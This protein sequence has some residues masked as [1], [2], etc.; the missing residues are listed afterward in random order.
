MGKYRKVPVV[1]EAEQFF[2][3]GDAG[4]VDMI[5]EKG[6]RVCDDCCA[7]LD[8]HGIIKTLEGHHIVCPS[9]WVITGVE[10]E[11]YPCKARIFAKTY[12]KVT[13]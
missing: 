4:V 11:R 3:Q 13:E 1:I 5:T 8:L 9:D 6:D 2:G 10:N 12:E 7:R